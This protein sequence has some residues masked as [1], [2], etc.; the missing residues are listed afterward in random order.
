MG[1]Q[2]K[3]ENL[4]FVCSLPYYAEE[5]SVS[6]MNGNVAFEEVSYFDVSFCKDRR[7]L[8]TFISSKDIRHLYTERVKA[9]YV[10]FSVSVIR[11]K[12]DG[13]KDFL[14]GEG[15]EQANESIEQD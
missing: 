11:L 8:I 2:G 5:D 1:N 13:V 4:D 7:V 3:D 6:H 9:D 14:P 15:T 12:I 10:T